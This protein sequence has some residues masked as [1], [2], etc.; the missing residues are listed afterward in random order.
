MS[1]GYIYCFSNESMKG[2][3]KVGMTERTP[4]IRL[5]E[6]NA[7]DTW[8]PPTPYKIEI[9]KKVFNPKQKETTLH[10][11]LS[12]YTERINP[13]REFFRI[14]SEEVKTFFELMDGELWLKTEEFTDEDTENEPE[15][16]DTEEQEEQE[17]QEE[18]ENPQSTQLSCKPCRDMSKYFTNG[19]HIRHSI[20]IDKIWIGIYDLSKNMIKC[21]GIFYSSLSGFAISHH[22]SEN[23]NRV[24]ANGW[25]ECQYELN[26][27]WTSINTIWIPIN[28]I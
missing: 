20:S 7:S 19:Q 23:N 24:T 11:L 2:I 13:K 28:T 12:Q 26:D 17:E 15:D 1:F 6:A 16:E 22:K 18:S 14:S 3:L 25:I 8:R 4:D 9:A 5:N 21:D 27:I 10:L